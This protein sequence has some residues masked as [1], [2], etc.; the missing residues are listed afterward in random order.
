MAVRPAT[1]L[2]PTAF[3][4]MLILMDAKFAE[5][6]FSGRNW[7]TELLQNCTTEEAKAQLLSKRAEFSSSSGGHLSA[8]Q[9]GYLYGAEEAISD[10]LNP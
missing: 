2:F 4:P 10:H 5:A 7:M 1:L 9:D 6:A 8:E 3:L